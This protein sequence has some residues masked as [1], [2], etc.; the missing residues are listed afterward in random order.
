MKQLT[1]DPHTPGRFRYNTYSDDFV[2]YAKLSVNGTCGH[3][4]QMLKFE[5]L[6]WLHSKVNEEK[7]VRKKNRLLEPAR[8]DLL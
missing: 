3:C 5:H 4:L 6:G 2:Q 1:S 7:I 8:F